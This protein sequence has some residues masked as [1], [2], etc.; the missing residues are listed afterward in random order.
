MILLYQMV[1]LI[2]FA[3]V[4]G[5]KFTCILKDSVTETLPRVDKTVA[6]SGHSFKQCPH[7]IRACD[8]EVDEGLGME[9]MNYDR[10]VTKN[11]EECQGRCTDDVHCHFV[12]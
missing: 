5:G 1:H 8:T 4:S 6:I 7:H 3:S 11:A 10:S 12:T 2:L 9:G